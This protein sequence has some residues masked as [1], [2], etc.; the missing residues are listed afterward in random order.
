MCDDCIHSNSC[1][2]K[3]GREG[4]RKITVCSIYDVSPVD[5]HDEDKKGE[6]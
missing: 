6:E 4:D 5:I 1:K 3:D 2:V